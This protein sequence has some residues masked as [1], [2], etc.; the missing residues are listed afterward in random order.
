MSLPR[1][2]E[3]PIGRKHA[4]EGFDC[5]DEALNEFL[6]RYARKSHQAGGSK[7]FVAVD[8][9][10]GK[11]ILGFYTLSPVSV[12]YARAPDV[13]KRGLG[14]HDVP[15]F[16]LARLAVDRSVQGKGLGG[17]LLLAAGRRSLRVASEVG[18][19]MLVID[20]K[21]EDV[22]AWYARYGAIALEA[23]PLI[24][25]LPLATIAAALNAAGKE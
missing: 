16:R 3:E 7:T 6:R 23:S 22:A 18:G 15:G 20:T 13:V 14:R 17:Q 19:V 8:D 12:E 21:N 2:R 5:G 4:R 9:A 25:V 11:T 1:W 24:L 10:D